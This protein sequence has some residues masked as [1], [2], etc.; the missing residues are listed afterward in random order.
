LRAL[1]I[2]FTACGKSMRDRG[3]EEPIAIT[4][5]LVHTSLASVDAAALINRRARATWPR[6]LGE[7]SARQRSSPRAVTA[8]SR[9]QG[10]VWSVPPSMASNA[11]N[12]SADP[13]AGCLGGRRAADAREEAAYA[14]LRFCPS[15]GRTFTSLLFGAGE[16]W[17]RRYGSEPG[18][19]T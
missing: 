2:R 16:T 10:I 7:R 3:F 9:R 18:D 1:S 6:S 17:L 8:C 12:R 5:W 19:G 4:P 15:L 11:R 13:R 14:S